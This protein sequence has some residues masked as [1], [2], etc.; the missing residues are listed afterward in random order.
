MDSEYLQ[1]D[2]D[3]EIQTGAEVITILKRAV[4]THQALLAEEV[5]QEHKAVERRSDKLLKELQEETD[6]LQRRHSELQN[7]KDSE[8][9]LHLIQ[10]TR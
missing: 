8:D 2:K 9:P 10:V 3:R 5:E 6:E 1:K 4:E 7:L